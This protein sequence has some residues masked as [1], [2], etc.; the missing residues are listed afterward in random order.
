MVKTL[1]QFIL[2]L[3]D[4]MEVL[5][6]LASFGKD[7]STRLAT[8]LILVLLFSCEKNNEEVQKDPNIIIIYTDQQRYNTIRALGYSHMHTPNLDKLVKN[9]VAF[10]ESFVT[11]PV[12]SPS[13]W[14]LFSGMYT[15]S[16]ATYSNHHHGKRPSTNLLLELKKKGYTT[17]LFGKNHSFLNER[18]LD[19]NHAT[20]KFEDHPH[21]GRNAMR[22]LNWDP[23]KDPM[24]VLT[25]STMALLRENKGVK[26]TFIWLSYLYPHT[27]YGISEPYY[28]MYDEVDIPKPITEPKG[29]KAANKPFRQIY[30]QE[31][32]D[33]LKTYD[34]EVVMRMRRNYYGMISMIDDEVGRLIDFLEKQGIKENTLIVFTSDHG[35]YMGDHGLMTKS[36]AMYDCLTRVPLIFSW[37]GVF[38]ENLISDEL[39]SN[40]DIM[41]TILSLIDAPI[42]ENVQGLDFSQYLKKGKKEGQSYREYVFSEYGI[43]GQAVNRQSLEELMPDYKEKAVYYN[44]PIV[45]WEANPFSLAGRFRM[46]RSHNWKYVENKGDISELYDLKNDPNELTNLWGNTDYIEIQDSLQKALNKWKS[47][48]PGIEKDTM[49]MSEDNISRYLEKRKKL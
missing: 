7:R 34:L 11:A 15:T 19:I 21:D 17:A 31:N 37:K 33:L 22:P 42:P 25:D 24:R 27:P 30:H 35:D 23:Q 16:H 38:K 47:S 36:P 29:L 18:D 8:V 49:D 40:I 9:G 26:P 44:N 43:P 2:D 41:P 39:I 5:Q 3:I 10:S 13:R 6:S 12:C 28:S 48:L 1:L 45:P 4:G 32:N 20:P 46:I 14:S